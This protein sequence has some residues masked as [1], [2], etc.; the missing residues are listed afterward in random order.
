MTYSYSQISQ[1]L[2]CPRRYRFRYLDGW[3]QDNRASMLFGRAFEQALGALFCKEDPGDVFYREWSAC[4]DQGLQFSGRDNWDRMLKQGIILLTR[5]CQ[6]HRIR[7]QQPRR[8]LQIKV[9][10][11]LGRR[12]DFVAYLDA[13]GE[14]DIDLAGS[15]SVLELACRCLLSSLTSR[16]GYAGRRQEFR[17]RSN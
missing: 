17:R 13:I 14:F 6:D 3:K 16:P 1:Y 10:K 4:K 11:P 2:T 7:I 15:G 9:V 12:R 5:F 8:H